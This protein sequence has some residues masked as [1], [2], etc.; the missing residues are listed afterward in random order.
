[1]VGEM[2]RALRLRCPRNSNVVS[3]PVA[4]DRLMYQNIVR[5]DAQM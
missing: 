1:M 4:P 5:Y 3:T 2:L